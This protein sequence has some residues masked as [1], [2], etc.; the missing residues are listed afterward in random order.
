MG[1]LMLHGVLNMPPELWGDDPMGLQQRHGRYK[2]ASQRIKDD[3]LTIERLLTL[4]RELHDEQNDAPLESRRAEW[5]SVMRRTR[6]VLRD[7]ERHNAPVQPK[8]G[9]G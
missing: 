1:D 7:F 3:A 6:E 8:T 5:E 9:K 2:Q 4:L